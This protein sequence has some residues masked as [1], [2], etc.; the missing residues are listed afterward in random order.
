MKG[1][2][3]LWISQVSESEYTTKHYLC[4]IIAFERWADKNHGLIVRNIPKLWRQAKYENESTKEQYLD[5]LK[6]IVNDYF[7]HL[8]QSGLAPMTINRTMSIV[9]SFLHHYDIPIKPIRIKHPFILYHNRDITKKELQMILEHSGIRNRA[10][11]LMLFESGLRPATLVSLKWRHIKTDFMERNVPMKIELPSD[12]LKCRVSERFTFIGRQ[13]Y[14]TLEAYLKTRLP[15]KDEDY[16]FEREKPSNGKLKVTAVS[17]AFN[18]TV[19]K[20]HLAESKGKAK[21]KALRTYCLRKAFRKFMAAE[22]DQAYPEYWMGHTSTSTYYLSQDVEHHRQLY[23]KGYKALK[24]SETSE[25]S[26]E[27]L[28]LLREK[29]TILQ[30]QDQAIQKLAIQNKNL[31]Q[32]LD[33]V[34][35][36]QEKQSKLLKP[37]LDMATKLKEDE[38]LGFDVRVV[39]EAKIKEEGYESPPNAY[40]A[41]FLRKKEDKKRPKSTE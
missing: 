6:D 29:E 20:L 9:M 18:K 17:Q 26:L 13:G 24:L 22:I 41:Q 15:L 32:I 19:Q 33:K 28:E 39:P 8:K 25:E 7:V 5:M 12:V 31:Q 11:F 36:D 3:E 35:E 2:Y 30:Q 34:L 1:V 27:I 40:H 16:L 21:P 4:D 37:L 23:A 10:M 14:D 38:V